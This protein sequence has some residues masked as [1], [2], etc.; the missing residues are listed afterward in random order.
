MR[1]L[2]IALALSAC[3]PSI[4]FS[5]EFDKSAP[6]VAVAVLPVQSETDVPKDQLSKL[7]QVLTSELRSAGF[8]VLDEAL[9]SEVCKDQ[10]CSDV[11][12]LVETY[13]LG[14]AYRL[15]V[16]DYSHIGFLLGFYTTVGGKLALVSDSNGELLEVE[17]QE[18][19]RGGLIFDSGQV[20]TAIKSL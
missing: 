7:H 12:S 18:S 19:K 1:I 14:G 2:I 6:P 13:E 16:T 15:V 11:A 20:L 9:T 17:H 3:G 4:K 8:L 5:Q 10:E